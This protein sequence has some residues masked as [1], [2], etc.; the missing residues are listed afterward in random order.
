MSPKPVASAL[1]L[2]AITGAFWLLLDPHQGH[3]IPASLTGP[4]SNNMSLSGPKP[5]TSAIQARQ[6]IFEVEV[7]NG[8]ES[9][10]EI[11]SDRSDEVNRCGL[12]LRTQITPDKQFQLAFLATERDISDRTLTVSISN[13]PGLKS[14]GTSTLS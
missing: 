3:F 1:L 13:L 5:R 4:H 9:F 11:V 10:L 8:D 6:S 7:R 12:D 14:I 2:I